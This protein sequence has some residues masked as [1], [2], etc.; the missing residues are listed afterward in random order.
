MADY[1]CQSCQTRIAQ[2]I[3]GDLTNGQQL[4]LCPVCVPAWGEA[5][6]SKLDHADDNPGLEPSADGI[7][8]ESPEMATAAAEAFLR[9]ELGIT[10]ITKDPCPRCLTPTPHDAEVP[11]AVCPW[12]GHDFVVA[13]ATAAAASGGPP[14]PPP[15]GSHADA[16]GEPPADD[17]ASLAADWEYPKR[18]GPPTPEPAAEAAADVDGAETPETSAAADVPG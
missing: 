8:A 12:C 18:D 14:D 17:L 4:Y 5:I 9:D 6:A 7:G 15:S 11:A 16:P 2:F 1:P 13:D 10:S 3:I